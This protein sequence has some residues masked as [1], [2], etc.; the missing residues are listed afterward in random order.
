MAL[1]THVTNRVSSQRL[2]ALTNP[3]LPTATSNDTARLGYACTDVES[4]FETY[5]GRA[6]DDDTA[7]DVSIAVDGVV[8]KLMLRMASGGESANQAHESYIE[9]LKDHRKRL[10]PKSSSMLTPTKEDRGTGNTIRPNFDR[11][12]FDDF[13]PQ[14]P[15]G[16]SRTQSET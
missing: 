9:R 3:D 2:I 5:L 1:S 8:S 10:L 15:R 6:Y 13:V 16:M 11:S 4:D 12:Q 14:H 7:G